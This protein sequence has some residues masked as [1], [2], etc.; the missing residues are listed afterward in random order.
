MILDL[1]THTM[2]SYDAEHQ[3]VAAHVQSAVQ[4]H[5]DVL[6]FTDHVEFF[7]GKQYKNR[8]FRQIP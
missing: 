2:Y 4:K 6:G 7:C 5:V 3:P 8:I 1:H